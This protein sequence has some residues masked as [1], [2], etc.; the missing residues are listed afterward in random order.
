MLCKTTTPSERGTFAAIYPDQDLRWV[1]LVRATKATSLGFSSSPMRNAARFVD[2]RSARRGRRGP[3]RSGE[4]HPHSVRSSL[5]CRRGVG[6]G[7]PHLVRHHGRRQRQAL[8]FRCGFV[9]AAEAALLACWRIVPPRPSKTPF[10]SMPRNSSGSTPNRLSRRNWQPCLLP[11]PRW[12]GSC[13]TTTGGTTI[14]TT[15]ECGSVAAIG[16]RRSERSHTVCPTTSLAIFG[17]GL[18]PSGFARRC[19]HS[20][21]KRENIRWET[22]ERPLLFLAISH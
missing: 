10:G 3:V 21:L 8:F 19:P 9:E 13:G 11:R 4:R 6:L 2:Q 7:L 22:S 12:C 1:K 16:R 17:L 5:P 14:A 18:P 15:G 20:R